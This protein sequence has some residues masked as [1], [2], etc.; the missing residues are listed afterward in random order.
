MNDA[1]PA[2]RLVVPADDGTEQ[3]TAPPEWLAAATAGDAPGP[4]DAPADGPA[5]AP[6]DAPADGAGDGEADGHA[7]TLGLSVSAADRGAVLARHW[8]RMITESARKSAGRPGS[9][10]TDAPPS[11]AHIAAYYAAAPWVPDNSESGLLTAA[12]RAYGYAIGLPLV[13]LFYCLAWLA[14]RPVRLGLALL[15]TGAVIVAALA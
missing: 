1:A 10:L 14:A 2:L 6:G 5:D 15:I 4:G 3:D 8:L 11:I 12:G 13:A 7:V 9:V